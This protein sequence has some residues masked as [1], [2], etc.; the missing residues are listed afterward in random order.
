MSRWSIVSFDEERSLEDEERSLGDRAT[1]E[2]YFV[3]VP[4][5]GKGPSTK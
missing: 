5:R 4:G 3:L 2:E 1:Y